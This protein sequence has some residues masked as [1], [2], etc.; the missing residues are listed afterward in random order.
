MSFV[1]ELWLAIV[2]SAVLVFIMS[3][4]VHMVFKYH[5]GEVNAA[6]NQDALQNAI[7]GAAPGVYAFPMAADPKD[8]MSPEWMKKWS[9]GPSAFLTVMRAGYSGMGPMLGKWFVFNL[10]VSFF[11]AYVA[12]HA[13]AMGAGGPSYLPVFRVVGTIGL[14]AYGFAYT[15]DAIWFGKPWRMWATNMLDALLY[16]LVMAGTFGWLWPR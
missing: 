15:G 3:A 5:N 1:G 2:L 12:A 11:T 10:V 13:L 9:E 7:R 4:L 6:P 16:G 8:R 14:M